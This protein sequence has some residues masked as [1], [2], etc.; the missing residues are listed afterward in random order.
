MATIVKRTDDFIFADFYAVG[1]NQKR[2]SG[3]R[4]RGV[5]D[6]VSARQDWEMAPRTVLFSVPSLCSSLEH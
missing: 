6:R 3:G 5:K 4:R 1:R 2:P